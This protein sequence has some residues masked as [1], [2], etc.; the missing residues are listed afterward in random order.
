MTARQT[1]FHRKVAADIVLHGQSVVGVFGEPPFSYTIGNHGVGLPELLVLGIDPGDAC[2]VLNR[3][4]AMQRELGKPLIGD[5]SLGEG[6][7]QPLRLRAVADERR[8][9]DEYTCQVYVHYQTEDYAVTQV[10][11]PD[12]EGRFP[13]DAGCAEPFGRVPIFGQ[14]ASLPGSASVLSPQNTAW[15]AREVRRTS[16]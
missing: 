12:K 4:G 7:A 1:E 11:I 5:V 15:N 16:A 2:W 9:K 10:L 8:V 3:L 14:A 13:G 6:A